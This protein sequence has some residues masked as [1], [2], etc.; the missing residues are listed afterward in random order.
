M[1]AR[2]VPTGL[3]VIVIVPV[4]SAEAVNASKA[5]TALARPMS[6]SNEK[7]HRNPSTTGF[8]RSLGLTRD[9]TVGSE[10]AKKTFKLGRKN[11]SLR[12]ESV[13]YEEVSGNHTVSSM[14]GCGFAKRRR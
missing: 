6:Q 1:A 10:R 14:Y 3:W 11:V 12:Q 5:T 2:G 8:S 13:G 4:L 7:N 9:S